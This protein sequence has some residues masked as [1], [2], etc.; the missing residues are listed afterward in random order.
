MPMLCL[1]LEV[2]LLADHNSM[3]VPGMDFEIVTAV[4]DELPQA[5]RAKE[6]E[7]NFL[8]GINVADAWDSAF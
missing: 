6:T 5:V 8:S 2:V 4:D 3:I 1:F 7:V